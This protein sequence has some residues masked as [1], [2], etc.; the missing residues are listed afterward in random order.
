MLDSKIIKKYNSYNVFGENI[1]KNINTNQTLFYLGE[2]DVY[3]QLNGNK[4]RLDTIYNPSVEAKNWY[5]KN[6]ERLKNTPNKVSGLK[7]IHK[8]IKNHFFTIPENDKT[9]LIEKIKN[10]G[11]LNILD[12]QINEITKKIKN[13]LNKEYLITVDDYNKPV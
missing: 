3:L 9:N 12:I 13:R 4:V 6:K 5:N 2:I 7:S 8:Y 11:F 1:G 10:M